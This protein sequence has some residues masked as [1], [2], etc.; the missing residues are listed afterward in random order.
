MVMDTRWFPAD[1]RTEAKKSAR[2]KKSH[3]WKY[4]IST[5]SGKKV[6]YY[7]GSAVPKVLLERKATVEDVAV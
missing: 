6:G 1:E 3:I 5:R 4:T 7:V 2:K